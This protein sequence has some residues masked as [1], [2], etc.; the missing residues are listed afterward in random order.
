MRLTHL[1]L[2]DF[3]PY[4]DLDLDLDGVG[5]IAIVGPNGSGKSSLLDA[6]LWCT[7]GQA[8]A[9]SDQLVREGAQKALV[10]TTWDAHGTSIVIERTRDR[11]TEQTAL[12]LFVD[13]DNRTRHT[14][15]D[16]QA[17][18]VEIIGLAAP[19]LLAGPV[20]VQG[21]SG[22]LMNAQPAER[23]EILGQLFELNRFEVYHDRAR[24]ASAAEKSSMEASQARASRLQEV[25]DEEL[26]ARAIK[27]DAEAAV[28]VHRRDVAARSTKVD[29]LRERAVAMRERTRL[30][31][32]HRMTAEAAAERLQRL[33]RDLADLDSEVGVYKK[34]AALMIPPVESGASVRLDELAA[35][36][37]HYAEANLRANLMSSVPCFGEGV[38]ASCQ[39][40]VDTRAGRDAIPDL[41]A[42]I[43][44]LGGPLDPDALA[45]R[46]REV[47]EVERKAAVLVERKAA[48]VYWLEKERRTRVALLTS[49]A[50][51]KTDRKK[52][53]RALKE[54]NFDAETVARVARDLASA[55]EELSLSQQQLE[56]ALT[57]V[58]MA[59]ARLAGIAKAKSELAVARADQRRHEVKLGIYQTLMRAFGRD[60][61]PTLVLENGIPLIEARANEI[62]ARMPGGFTV[63][64]VTQRETKAGSVRDT[65]DVLVSSDGIERSYALL[66]GGERL[67]VDFALR[68]A[69]ADV[70]VRR[71]G[72]SFET[73]WIDEGFGSQDRNGREA[74]LEAI[75]AVAQ[76][77][78]LIVVVSHVEDVT[79]RFETRLVVEKDEAG[80]ATA[81]VAG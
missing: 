49:I 55:V 7:Y 21:M 31:E 32:D 28:S 42:R 38:F 17:S 75:A 54:L 80:V 52:A 63:S 18:I 40:L 73:L 81:Q 58:G 30:A 4:A 46:R 77:F 26:A 22:A 65:L 68:V 62:L 60:G 25:V 35:V 47:L 6:V 43:A 70:L 45:A 66:S 27:R 3:L 29:L 69:L 8:R 9:R 48:A 67:R 14:I 50:E 56:A 13:G 59:E 57:D 20:M 53:Q 72:R 78:G 5:Q 34:R 44:D 33:G 64:M 76:D 41:V 71:A 24:D 2:V 15:A 10:Q 37:R 23:K 79:D 1:R 19:A 12:T 74:M 51:A 61:I 39:F 16:T 36:Q 11:T